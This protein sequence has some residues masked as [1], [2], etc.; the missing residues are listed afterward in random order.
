[1]IRLRR[2]LGCFPAGT[3]VVLDARAETMMSLMGM[4]TAVEAEP[5]L[6]AMT[7]AQLA[8]LAAERGLEVGPRATKAQI[9][10]VI[11]RAS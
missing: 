7:K 6:E 5:D 8:H 1:M 10:E 4:A 2:R 11:R 3:A 9:A